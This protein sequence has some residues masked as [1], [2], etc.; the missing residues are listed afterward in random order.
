MRALRIHLTQS[1]ANYRKEETI[2]NKMTYPLPPLSTIIG[3]IH[4]ACNFKE[5]HEMDIS[6]QGDYKTMGKEVYRDQAYLNTTFDDRGILVKMANSDCLANAFVKVA[7]SL[8]QGS[9]FKSGKD[10][11]VHN[12]ALLQ[13]YRELKELKEKIDLYKKETATPKMTE[14][15]NMRKELANKKKA[16]DKSTDEYKE[17]DNKDKELKSE[18]DKITNELK[19]YEQKNYTEPYSQFRTL[20]GSIKYYE[21]LYDIELYI[22]ISADDDTLQKIYDNIY[23]LTSLGRS[24][25]FVDVKSAEFVELSKPDKEYTSGN[26]HAYISEECIENE[27]VF[28]TRNS[29]H[30]SKGTKYYIC[31]NYEIKDQKRIFNKKKLYYISQYAVDDVSENVYIDKTGGKNL[32]VQFN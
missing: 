2:I 8:K 4:N 6:V 24:E 12:D 28:I 29:N 11:T 30:G 25:D 23:N 21:V 3:A 32:I 5:Y 18:L 7:T 15:K 13:E 31:K 10:I 17:I 27:H 26:M 22:H 16:L 14:I 1:S 9:S 19:E 20:N